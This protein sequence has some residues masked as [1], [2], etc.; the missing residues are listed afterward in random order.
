MT[1]AALPPSGVPAALARQGGHESHVSSPG[2]NVLDLPEPIALSAAPQHVDPI[3]DGIPA[4]ACAAVVVDLS[5][6]RTNYRALRM[7]AGRSECAGVVKADAYGLGLE[8]VV[9][10]L[11]AEGCRVF[12]VANIDEAWRARQLAPQATI[13][14]LNGL[15]PGTVPVFTELMAQPVLGSVPEIE[16]WAAACTQAGQR[17]PAAV[18]VDT[19]MNRLGLTMREMQDLLRRQVFGSFD[20]SL[21]ISH[22][23]NADSPGS[24]MNARQR[25][26]FDAAR[27][28]FPNVPASLANSAGTML[29]PPFHYDMVRPGIAIYGG[30]AM[31]TV[32]NPMKPAVRLLARI[33]QVREIAAGE[34]V[35]YGQTFKAPR[36]SRIAVVAAGYADGLPRGVTNGSVTMGP[37]VPLSL[38]ESVRPGVGSMAYIQGYP[39][40]IV[41]RVSMDLIAID[42]TEMPANKLVRGDFAELIGRNTPADDIAA[43][44]ETIGYEVLTRL[45]RRA[46]R[47]YLGMSE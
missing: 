23:V 12:F 37:G 30:R 7:I 46:H 24:A 19:G 45:S 14:V 27:A 28:T 15:F 42:V 22:L 9:R 21:V 43:C 17:W 31:K 34:T 20:V 2:S 13:Y 10:A 39:V 29:G 25:Q 26:R 8:P 16:E 41:G 44:A 18:H 3:P 6:V 47:V 38:A 40:P 4:H 1:R 36:P 11:L 35:G 5:A 33:V 32:Q